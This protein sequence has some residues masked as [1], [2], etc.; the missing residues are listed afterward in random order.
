MERS[1]GAEQYMVLEKMCLN[2]SGSR[3]VNCSDL[4]VALSKEFSKANITDLLYQNETQSA[5]L[6]T[7]TLGDL[8]P[9]SLQ[10]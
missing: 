3:R 1:V 4:S 7:K 9:T 6:P 2:I 10:P 8:N 5:K